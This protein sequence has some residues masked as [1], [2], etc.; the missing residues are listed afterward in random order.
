[1]ISS[2]L[3]KKC[4]LNLLIIFGVFLALVFGISG[5]FFVLSKSSGYLYYF[6]MFTG[7]ASV[8]SILIGWVVGNRVTY[9]YRRESKN[10]N[11]QL[12]LDVLNKKLDIRSPFV[13]N[14]LVLA[15]IYFCIELTVKLI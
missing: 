10:Y 1:M 7:V 6:C 4:V 8:I 9:A 2:S 15:V 5:I 12:P 13:I 3:N 14:G 11:G